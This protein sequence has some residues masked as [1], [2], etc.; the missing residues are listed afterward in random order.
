MD[1]GFN[2]VEKTK[3]RK[4]R[5][6]GDRNEFSAKVRKEIKDYF[7]HE[8]QM[9]YGPGETIHHV[10]LRAQSGR[11]VFTNGLLLCHRCHQYLHDNPKEL[12]KW[13]NR[14]REWYGKSYFKDKQD[15]ERE[16]AD[17][18]SRKEKTEYYNLS[19]MRRT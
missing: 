13:Q 9:C 4:K 3:A 10:H 18:I 19:P 1:W 8:C 5:K 7:N 16:A 2:P 11:G 15:L 17:L 6:R 14:F 12:K